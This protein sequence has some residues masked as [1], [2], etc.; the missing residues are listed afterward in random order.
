[1]RFRVAASPGMGPLDEL[2]AQA[3]TRDATLAAVSER[4]AWSLGGLDLAEDPLDIEIVLD[5][6]GFR[7]RVASVV[8]WGRKKPTI[9]APLADVAE[10]TLTVD[11][12]LTG[13]ITVTLRARDAD[14]DHD[15]D[16]FKGC[17]RKTTCCAGEEAE[18]FGDC[19]DDD[20]RF[21]PFADNTNCRTCGEREACLAG[22]GDD[23]SVET[24]ERADVADGSLVDAADA[25][26]S[27]T[28][29]A[30]DE[31]LC[32]DGCDFQPTNVKC[33]H[34]QWTVFECQNG[35]ACGED[36]YVKY[37]DRYCSG[38]SAGCSGEVKWSEP[39]KVGPEG[40]DG[41]CS[42]EERCV[43][44][45][46]SCVSDDICK[47]LTPGFKMVGEG[48]FWMGSAGAAC[49]AGQVCSNGDCPDEYPGT[50]KDEHMMWL[51]EENLHYVR[52]TR[53]FEIMEREVTQAEFLEP[54]ADGGMGYNPSQFQTCGGDGRNCPVE[55]VSWHEALAYANN[56]SRKR[57]LEEC[58]DCAGIP[59]DN[60]CALKPKFAR[61]QE[62]PGFRLPTEA[63]WEYAY[64]AGSTTPYYPSD[65]NNGSVTISLPSTSCEADTNLGQIAWYCANGSESTHVAGKAGGKEPNAWGLYDMAGNVWE[66]CWDVAVIP[67]PEALSVGTTAA[68][69]VDPAGVVDDAA[70]G[71]IVRGGAY[72]DRAGY[73]R[74]ASRVSWAAGYRNYNVGFRLCRTLGL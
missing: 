31:G 2:V 61:P 41:N 43:P 3:K 8:L 53:P 58:F 28:G 35:T 67:L 55:Q 42:A 14:C 33:Q 73:A 71:R 16:G 48:E 50:C 56:W 22:G 30:C 29:C 27:D 59:P 11:L 49:A 46:S 37:G 38:T 63:E 9:D 39:E 18:W 74:A 34:H 5:N 23:Q 1:M 47:E 51:G 66:W 69:E 70:G 68:P 13:T 52:L 62:C 45:K 21:N 6:D 44:T 36:V 17:E 60:T 4:V 12:S 32:C 26:S 7:Q 20:P 19:D 40:G 72:T 64:R 15:G 65:G 10:A 57:G 25:E 54:A 24:A